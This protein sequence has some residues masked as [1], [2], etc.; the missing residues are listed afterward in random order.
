MLTA[1]SRDRTEA[2]VFVHGNSGQPWRRMTSSAPHPGPWRPAAMVS[3]RLGVR[4]SQ[5]LLSRR[6]AVD[7]LA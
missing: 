2:T 4:Y 7:L 5:S 1:S 6:Q 3:R